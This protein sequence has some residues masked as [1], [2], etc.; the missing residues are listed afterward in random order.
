[1]L[2]SRKNIV[3]KSFAFIVGLALTSNVAIANSEHSPASAQLGATGDDLQAHIDAAMF[4]QNISGQA[5]TQKGV[6]FHNLLNT[7]GSKDL[8]WPNFPRTWHEQ[9]SSEVVTSNTYIGLPPSIASA[10]VYVNYRYSLRTSLVIV[11]ANL[12]TE[13]PVDSNGVTINPVSDPLQLE[14]FKWDPIGHRALP[15]VR[16]HFPMV[17]F[18][19]YEASLNYS[20][21]A[22]GGISFFGSGVSV[23]NEN[24]SSVNHTLFSRFF[25]VDGKSSPSQM[26]Q[27]ICAKQFR[28]QVEK[29]VQAD[30]SRTVVE[31]NANYSSDNECQPSGDDNAGGDGGCKDWFDKNI[32]SAVR[33]ITVPRCVYTSTGVHRC[34]AMSHV[35]G[36][37][38]MVWDPES[39]A[40]LPRSRVLSGQFTRVTD[41]PFEYDCDTGLTCTM[42]TEPVMLMGT[43][44][45]SGKARCLTSP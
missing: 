19:A 6:A 28:P 18:C 21:G 11:A 22:R 42:I 7:D 27:N 5:L 40:A 9:S 14:V 20:V 4:Q 12:S 17:A 45:W 23:D 29:Y 34:Q 13:Q 30:F 25:Q 39:K 35:D 36:N 26:L 44:V 31:L 16:K 43:V 1:M 15:N 10:A 2:M 41:S 33:N 32:D 8:E 24:V 37:C 38:G 3:I